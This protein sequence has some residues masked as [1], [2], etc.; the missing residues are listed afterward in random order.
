MTRPGDPAGPFHFSF[1]GAPDPRGGPTWS[2]GMGWPFVRSVV[3][4]DEVD[5]TSDLARAMVLAGWSAFPLLVRAR[6]Q[7]RGRGRG[8]NSWW[9]DRGS[10]TF[11]LVVDPAALGLTP[12]HEPRVALAAAVAVVDAVAAFVPPG[13]PLGIRWPNDVEAGGRKLGGI[14]PEKVVS[15]GGPRLLIGIGLNVLTRLEHAPP[16]VRALAASLAE[17]ASP[18]DEGPEPDRIL[19]STL[20]GLEA[21]LPRLTRNDPSLAEHWASLDLLA[22]GPVRVDLGPRTVS[23][24]GAG[25]DA[26]GALLVD[27]GTETVRLLGG[28]VL[29]DP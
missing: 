28:R 27:T 4:R 24:R 6:R 10:L 18:V 21:V 19:V 25:I 7:S 22:G 8:E 17:D 20:A 23:G 16:D 12:A 26:E 15:P 11:T 5:S 29:R 14:L 9:S 3:D 2:P 13:K 1:R